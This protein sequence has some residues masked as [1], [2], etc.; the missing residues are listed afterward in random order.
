MQ[1]FL[2]HWSYGL[3]FLVI[4]YGFMYLNKVI[5]DKL[6]TVNGNDFYNAVEEESNLAV[7]LRRSGL[8]LAVALGMV[9][10]ISGPSSGFIKDVVDIISYGAFVSLL[11]VFARYI[12]DAF[13][14]RGINNTKE[15][16]K[17]NNSVGFAEFGCFIATGV[18]LMASMT[19]TGG[20][21]VT[22][23]VFFGLGQLAILVSV[24]AYEKFTPWGVIEQIK[25]GNTS[26]GLKVG[27]LAVALSVA[28]YGTIA[29]DFVGWAD[30]LFFVSLESVFAI[31][32]LIFLS[33]GVDR[34]FLPN[35][36][37]ETEIVRDNNSAAVA[38]VVAM[39]IVGALIIS[40]SIT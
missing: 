9:G 13:V 10:V 40:A 24:L 38:L 11:M 17:K 31:T 22:A 2:I 33:I 6:P 39:Q 23:L 18:M 14:L 3:T 15:I 34:V 12:N 30:T 35:T 4:A 29:R 25:N 8:L 36:D 5:D 32:L 21:I 20:N 37:M 28:L 7:A 26:A 19:G 16:Y 1:E 27:G